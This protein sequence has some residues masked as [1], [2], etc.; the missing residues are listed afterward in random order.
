LGKGNDDL[1]TSGY[2]AA[3]WC[4]LSFKWAYMLGW[5]VFLFLFVVCWYGIR[6]KD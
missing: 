1:V 3:V 6:C 2:V 4:M 5:Y